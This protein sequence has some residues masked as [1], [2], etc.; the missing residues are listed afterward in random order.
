MAAGNLNHENPTRGSQHPVVT[1]ADHVSASSSPMTGASSPQAD[2]NPQTT[3]A[4]SCDAEQVDV[5][6]SMGG[7][8]ENASGAASATY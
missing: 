2:Y 1:T 3:A 7:V 6:I 8:Q 5:D 4:S